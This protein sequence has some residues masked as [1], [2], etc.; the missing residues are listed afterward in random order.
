MNMD[1]IAQIYFSQNDLK[2][3]DGTWKMF[4]LVKF[5]MKKHAST[6]SKDLHLTPLT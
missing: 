5:I 2:T 3:E 6:L 1:S 4:K